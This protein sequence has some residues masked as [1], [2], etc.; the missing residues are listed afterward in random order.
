M[1]NGIDFVWIGVNITVLLFSV[2]L[3]ESA[4]AWVA[5][6]RGDSTGRLLGRISLNPLRH[7]DPVG[8]FLVPM[9]GI[10]TGAPIFGWARPVPVNPANFA[11]FRKDQLLVS[12]AGPVSNLL[13]AAGF[14]LVYRF[15]RVS[16]FVLEIVPEFLLG[17]LVLMC[18]VGILLNIILAVF[19][20]IPIPPLDGSWV[21]IGILP[22]EFGVY[23]DKVRPYG[24]MI[25]L[26]LLMTGGIG[27]IL[28]PVLESAMA[29]IR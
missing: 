26:V 9:I 3:H 18:Q 7:V 13:A 4:H 20:L 10:F 1:V 15:I 28:R 19:N 29:L 14:L 12:I 16:G 25:L 5:E 6:K 2:S 11:D 23:V 27:Y 8:S 21:L 17:P 24:F 22:P